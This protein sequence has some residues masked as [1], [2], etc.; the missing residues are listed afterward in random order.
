VAGVELQLRVL[1][2]AEIVDGEIGEAQDATTKVRR[3]D[4]Q[5]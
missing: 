2:A 3:R 5:T 4:A 1:D